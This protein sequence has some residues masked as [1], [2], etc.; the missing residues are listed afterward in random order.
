MN[1]SYIFFFFFQAEDGIRDKLVTG[2]QTCA[3]P[4]YGRGKDE[5]DVAVPSDVR[6]QQPSE[7]ASPPH[8]EEDVPPLGM[9]ERGSRQSPHGAGPDREG[10]RRED[11]PY[12]RP[13]VT[14]E[15]VDKQKVDDADRDH[16]GGH[17]LGKELG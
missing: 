5:P 11:V 6:L 14:L 17:G 9:D 8:V 1:S 2:V 13:R 4:I 12:D 3:L 7:V 15:E 16:N 10:A